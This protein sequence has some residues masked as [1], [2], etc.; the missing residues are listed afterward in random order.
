MSFYSTKNAMS[1]CCPGRVC[2]EGTQG[3]TERVCVQVKKVYDACMQQELS[4]IH[5]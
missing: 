3:V 5:I 1:S 4:L 2:G